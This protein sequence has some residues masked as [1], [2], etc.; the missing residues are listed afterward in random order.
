MKMQYVTKCYKLRDPKLT[1]SWPARWVLFIQ[2]F[3]DFVDLLPIV[4]NY[5]PPDFLEQ[6]VVKCICCLNECFSSI[7]LLAA[8]GILTHT[9]INVVESN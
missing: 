1:S 8:K 2:A 4:W 3:E 5:L 7:L 9:S 6:E